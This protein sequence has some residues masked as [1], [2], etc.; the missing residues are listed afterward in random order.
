MLNI[1]LCNLSL[2]SC[3]FILI[4]YSPLIEKQLCVTSVHLTGDIWANVFILVRALFR[5]QARDGSLVCAL[6]CAFCDNQRRL[7]NPF[8]STTQM[9][10]PSIYSCL[11]CDGSQGGN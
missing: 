9:K 8:D 5:K 6:V 10:R 7:F 11:A 1:L 2:N 3:L 4:F